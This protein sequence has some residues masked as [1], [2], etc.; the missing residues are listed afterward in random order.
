MASNT[1]STANTSEYLRVDGE[2]LEARVKLDLKGRQ[3]STGK[4]T[5]L[6]STCGFREI[7][8]AAGIRANITV[9]RK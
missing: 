3:S 1:K 5:I 8:G 4:S 7:A 9:I 6:T 2:Y